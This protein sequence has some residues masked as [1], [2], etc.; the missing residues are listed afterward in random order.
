MSYSL[1]IDKEAKLIKVTWS[2]E[3]LEEDIPVAFGELEELSR[4]HAG[5]NLLADHR[6]LAASPRVELLP[7]A[8]KFLQ[9]LARNL[10]PYKY[11]VVVDKKISYGTGR[12]VESRTFGTDVMVRPF[13]SIK[14]AES[15]LAQPWE[16]D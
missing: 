14:E 10:G 6:G 4:H 2:G 7:E 11:A 12:M 5:Y 8:I 16:E 13:Y 3:L 15:W 1:T 9:G